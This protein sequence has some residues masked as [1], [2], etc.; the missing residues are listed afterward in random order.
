MVKEDSE[1]ITIF[2]GDGCEEQKIEEFISNL[3]KKYLDVEIQSYNGKQPLY[4]FI[5]SV[6]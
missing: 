2:Y 1:L 5:V 6:E 4:Y 3:E